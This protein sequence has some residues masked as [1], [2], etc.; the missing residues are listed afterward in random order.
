MSAR[1]AA[2]P[3]CRVQRWRAP[4][5][6]GCRRRR[7]PPPSGCGTCTVSSEVAPCCQRAASEEAPIAPASASTARNAIAPTS[8]GS[9]RSES[10]RRRPRSSNPAG[11]RRALTRARHLASPAARRRGAAAAPRP[12][13]GR[14]R[15]PSS[16]PCSSSRARAGWRATSPSLWVATTTVVPSRFISLSSCISRSAWVSS[17]LPVGSSASSRLGRLITA[18]A[19]ATRC[20]SPPESSAGR[21]CWRRRQPDPAQHLGDVGADRPSGRPA[22][23]SGRAT[24]SYAERCGSRRKSWNTTPIRRRSRGSARRSARSTS[25]AQ[26]FEPPARRPH[27]EVQQPQQAGLAGAGGPEQPAERRRRASRSSARAAPP[28]R[29]PARRNAAQ[30]RPDA[31][32]RL[33][34]GQ[35]FRRP[36]T[37][38][39]SPGLHGRGCRGK[40][41]LRRRRATPRIVPCASSVPS[42]RPPTPCPTP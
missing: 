35:A 42:A 9:S 38:A 2:T 21:A 12:R 31:P 14:P 27:R 25:H 17:R 26:H 37:L 30:H 8:S 1:A 18:R 22:M 28:S 15:S 41:I 40:G 3:G 36:A 23:R 11:R 19:I 16:R 20:C 29:H 39:T 10:A 7:P 13:L 34:A 33:P 4:G 6:A 5:R 32:C 24:L